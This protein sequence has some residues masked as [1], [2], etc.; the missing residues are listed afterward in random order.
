MKRTMVI[1]VGLVLSL[2]LQACATKQA[3][4]RKNP[5]I[6]KVA[7]V[8]LSVSDWGGSVQANNVSRTSANKLIQD[9]INS[10]LTY[11]ERE[12][13][14]RWEVRKAA[15][16]V[17]NGSYR[18]Q[19]VDSALTV[20]VPRL[21]GKDM[22]VFTNVSREI[23]RGDLDAARARA[24]CKTLQV[25]AVVLVFSEWTAKTGGFVPITKAVTKNIVSVWDAQG[26]KLAMRRV[27]TMG[28][29]PLG[30]L[31][32]KTVNQTTIAEWTD[33]YKRSITQIV[34]QL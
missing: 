18:K 31:G 19:G 28:A 9:S 20:Y 30:A 24:L 22:P 33:T 5:A 23:K 12:L 14:T 4:L 21:K 3:S 29:K 11:T 16:F 25:D 32:I 2:Q 26:K 13:G 27:D 8:S 7:V 17:G 1:L 15:T 34:K 6:K 10:L